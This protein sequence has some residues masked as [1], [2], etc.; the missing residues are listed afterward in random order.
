MAGGGGLFVFFFG[1]FFV[2]E[3]S[4]T[5]DVLRIAFQGHKRPIVSQMGSLN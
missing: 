3:T 4:S 2:L 1:V 5:H